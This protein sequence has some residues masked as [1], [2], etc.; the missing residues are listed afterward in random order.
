MDI[1]TQA[2]STNEMKHQLGLGNG[3]GNSPFTKA[4]SKM[5]C[6]KD[7]ADLSMLIKLISVSSEKAALMEKLKR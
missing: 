2:F 7:M 1:I 5:Q 3:K 4:V 6:S